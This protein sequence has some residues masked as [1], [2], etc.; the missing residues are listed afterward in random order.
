[1]DK[2]GMCA[3]HTPYTYVASSLMEEGAQLECY[4]TV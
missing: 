1:M 2:D 4:Q 3:P